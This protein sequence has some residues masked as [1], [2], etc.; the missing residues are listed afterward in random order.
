MLACVPAS[1]LADS[2]PWQ[3][4][5]HVVMSEREKEG[6]SQGEPLA[7]AAAA[8]VTAASGVLALPLP[9]GS[10][11]LVAC[12]CVLERVRASLPSLTHSHPHSRASSLAAAAIT[13][14]TRPV[15]LI[16]SPSLPLYR[17][18]HPTPATLEERLLRQR[19]AQTTGQMPLPLT[20]RERERI[21]DYAVTR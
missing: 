3:S 16:H 10:E 1:S 4:S 19:K 21:P 6:T 18:L 8:L 12:V 17:S 11:C 9:L 20:Q 15:S 2:F 13:V 5:S 7:V 14:I